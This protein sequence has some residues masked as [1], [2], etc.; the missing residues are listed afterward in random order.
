MTAISGDRRQGSPF[1][2]KVLVFATLLVVLCSWN[3][4]RQPFRDRLEERNASDYGT[5][6]DGPA[7]A[8]A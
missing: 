5:T 3:A 8:T 2:L 4:V 6:A 1:L 7:R